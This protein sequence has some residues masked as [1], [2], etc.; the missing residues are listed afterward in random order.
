MTISSQYLQEL[1]LL[2]DYKRIN[3]VLLKNTDQTKK[4]IFDL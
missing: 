4:A 2:L 1:L 3:P